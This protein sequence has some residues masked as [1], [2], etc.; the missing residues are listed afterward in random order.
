MAKSLLVLLG[1]TKLESSLK[2]LDFI[3]FPNAWTWLFFYLENFQILKMAVL[4]SNFFKF[5]RL[6]SVTKIKYLPNISYFITN[7]DY[8]ESIYIKLDTILKLHVEYINQ[9]KLSTISIE[10]RLNFVSVWSFYFVVFAF[11]M[12]IKKLW[13]FTWI[14]H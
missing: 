1:F 2:F 12:I 6:T 10:T 7:H 4:W 14:G 3:F 5:S 9:L 8:G 13:Y 11:H